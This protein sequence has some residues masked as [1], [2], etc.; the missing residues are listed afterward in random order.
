[1]KGV[2]GF[3]KGHKHSEE[4]KLKIS[5]A[6]SNKIGF[7]CDYCG[8]ESTDKPSSYNRKKRHFCSRGCYS[9]YRKHKLPK[10]EQHRFGTGFSEEERKKRRGCRSETN[11]AIIKGLLIREPCEI[12]GD[13]KTEAHHNDY[14]KP[15]NVRWLCFIHHR[16]WHKE[17]PELLEE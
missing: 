2:K 12:C 16:A 15:L 9:L 10:H 7:N 3:I 4:T 14:D 17:N 6:L 13:K 11:K 8:N 5:K 1:M